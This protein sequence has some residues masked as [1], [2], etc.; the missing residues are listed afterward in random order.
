M[1]AW[2]VTAVGEPEE[3]L[4]LV[5]VPEAVAGDGEV[6]VE[7][8]AAA[9][10]FPD[11][12]T[13]QGLYHDKKP[14]PYVPGG[15]LAGTVAGTGRRVIVNPGGAGAL[16]ERTAVREDALLPIPDDL[17]DAK[18]AA[19]FVAY[20]T[21]YMA[22]FRRARL[23]DGETLLVHAA[24]GGVGSAA[25]QLGRAA[26]A[27][28]IAT[29]G[30]PEKA[31][32][33]RDLGADAVIDYRSDDFVAAVKDL[34][35]GRGADV[36][37]DPVGGDVFDKSRKCVAVEGRILVVGFASGRIPEMKVN[38]ALLKNYSVVGFRTRPF[39]DDPV[40]R[41][42]VH[43]DLLR[44]YAR[45]AIDPLVHEVPFAE[46]PAALARLGARGTTGRTVVRVR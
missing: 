25:V 32:V 7:V 45:G 29:A 14:V 17:P 3:V 1:R 18:A 9:L 38:H 37:Y 21:S 15:E 28:V 23:V 43:D 12:L 5:D 35:D 2:Q 31:R 10:G 27:R 34:T 33:C 41:R 11:L 22:L 19:L 20:Q 6:V 44:M 40:Y 13:C 8:A 16:C 42:E 30:G 26:G 4:R 46:A 36:I 24:A 39:R